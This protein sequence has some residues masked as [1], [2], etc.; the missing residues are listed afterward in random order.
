MKSTPARTFSR[1]KVC[2]PNYP[3]Y[4]Q[5]EIPAPA[6]IFVS[7]T[8]QRHHRLRFS[9]PIPSSH[10]SELKMQP[11]PSLESLAPRIIIMGPTNAGKSTLAVVISEKLNIPAVHLDRLRHLP[12]T[13]WQP[14]PDAE[15]AT[16]HDQA[17]LEPAWIMDG[18]Y[19]VLAPQRLERATAIL[20]V[21]ENLITRYRR[22][23]KR[24]LFQSNRAG[25][26]EGG[27]DGV[28]WNMLG[29][30]WKSRNAAS[31]YQAIARQTNL[32]HVFVNGAPEMNSL[33]AAWGLGSV[34]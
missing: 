14:R 26:L 15:F 9:T 24:S 29:W 25:A 12:N 28:N 6:G 13:N 27:Q 5:S 22:Y 8:G 1:N 18:N 10:I 33:Y 21:N 34:P 3:T 30:L 2:H 17:I 20:V 23:F 7:P 19:S 31:K 4:N 11:L 32:P 16:L